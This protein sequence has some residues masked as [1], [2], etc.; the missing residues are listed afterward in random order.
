MA[1]F[2]QCSLLKGRLRLSLGRK[3]QLGTEW[4]ER[5]LVSVLSHYGFQIVKYVLSLF[6]QGRPLA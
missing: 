2:R 6:A 3:A 1:Q 4:I 5:T